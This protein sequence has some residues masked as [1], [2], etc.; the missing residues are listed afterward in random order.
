L[1]DSTATAVIASLLIASAIAGVDRTGISHARRAA[2]ADR[3]E[4]E[5]VERRLQAAR[6]EVIGDHARARRKRGL[7]P[8]LG[9]QA[10]TRRVAR[11][12]SG[13]QH[14]RRVR[15]V[16][17]TGDRR[18]DDVAVAQRALA[19]CGRIAA[20]IERFAKGG[21]RIAERDPLVRAPR[22]RHARLS[23]RQ[24]DLDDL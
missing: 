18:D 11:E 5:R 13:A 9:L 12:Q 16:G 8:G 6:L 4:A 20:D 10:A 14:K 22:A 15:R 1:P 19:L 23:A 21:G 7:D 17:A 2:E 3:I 24:V